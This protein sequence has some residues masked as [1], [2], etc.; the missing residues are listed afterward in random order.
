MRNLLKGIKARRELKRVA[1]EYLINQIKH[2]NKINNSE[3]V[4]VATE[5]LK[6]STRR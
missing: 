3:L 4:E 5:L 2:H 6:N 1:R